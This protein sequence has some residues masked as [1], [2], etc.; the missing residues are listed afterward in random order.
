M[1]TTNTVEADTN[2]RLNDTKNLI[3][4][5]LKFLDNPN[6]EIAMEYSPRHEA[7]KIMLY[8][9]QHD[10]RKQ[11]SVYINRFDLNSDD[12]LNDILLDAFEY[13]K[14]KFENG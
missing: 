14:G 12:K 9:D 4:E 11:A 10:G 3:R 1:D 2:E 6:H 13:A 8:A 5:I 7:Y